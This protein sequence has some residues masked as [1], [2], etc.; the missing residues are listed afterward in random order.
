MAHGE[1]LLIVDGT[2]AHRDGMKRLFDDVGYVCTAVDTISFG[3]GLI[4]RL[5]QGT[6]VTLNR[7]PIPGGIWL[8]TSIR[9]AGEGRA[10]VFR[11]LNVDQRI[12]WS[13]YKK[14]LNVH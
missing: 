11:K 2:P 1:E 9:F 8:P 7:E 4:A 12:E 13:E 6:T 10:L 14:V 5:N 3:F